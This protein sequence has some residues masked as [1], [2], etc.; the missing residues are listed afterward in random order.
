MFALQDALGELRPT[1]ELRWLDLPPAWVVGLV[2]L[3][4]L[5]ALAWFCYRSE[6]VRPG[7]RW[8][9]TGLRFA[10]LVA[11]AAILARPALVR[12]QEEV[13]SPEVMVLLDDSASMRRS[14]AYADDEAARRAIADLGLG[15]DA[16][17]LDVATRLLDRG[18]TGPLA[19]RGWV[20]NTLAFD[21][22]TRPVDGTEAL[23]ARG[24]ATHLGDA[25]TTAVS[26]YRGRHP[27][28]LLVLTDGRSNGGADVLEGA[29]VA[30]IAG[31]EVHSVVVGDTR[32]LKNA[33]LELVEAP[34]SALEGDELSFAVRVQGRGA[35]IGRRVEV[36]LEEVT[37]AGTRE[38]LDSREVELEAAGRRVVLVAPPGPGDAESGERR[39]ELTVPPLEDETLVDDNS[40]SVAVRV[41]PEKVRVLYVEGYPRWEYRRLALDFLKRAEKDIEFQAWLQ[42]SSPGFP[43]E[44]GP[45]SKP[46]ERLPTTREELLDA[47][48][49]VILGDVNPYRLFDDPA[50]GEAFAAALVSF[51][52]SGGGL[53]FQAGEQDNPRALL[54]TPLED[55]LPVIVD[56]S[57]DLFFELDTTK[58]FRPVLENASVPHE[59]VRLH[60]DPDTNRRLWEDEDGLQGVFW[61]SGVTRAKTSADV[62]LRH[63]NDEN[64][65]GR[66]PLLVAGYYPQGRTLFLALDSTWR[67]Q[68]QYG[69]RYFER[70]WK[71]AIRWLSLGRL[72][73][74]DRRVR[75]ETPRS[76]Y[77]LDE[78]VPLE[79]RLLGP[80]WRPSEQESVRVEIEDE[81]GEQRS[82][83]LEADPGR[84]GTFGGEIDLDQPGTYGAWVETEGRR[85]ASVA[86]EV[87]LPSKENADPTPD[88]ALLAAAAR[89]SGGTSAVVGSWRDVLAA[90]DEGRERREP[91]NSSLEDFWDR[92][93]VLLGILALLA[94]EW[95]VRKRAELL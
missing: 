13:L 19:D 54:G 90:F 68:W 34:A 75:L 27:V 86:F 95:L 49:V 16:S 59:I 52:E 80:D 65:F 78:A 85:A 89:L 44:H 70:F 38:L 67:W 14:D 56:T 1:A 31:L 10:A 66:R 47:Y 17:R 83:V 6:P 20:V 53:M 29:R 79:V 45:G 61:Y 40:A 26:R 43:Q 15:P 74:G 62:L 9:L 87:V 25:I 11:V 32:P 84:P 81:S 35:A 77:G 37:E 50:D 57:E 4:A 39:L 82:V 71:S 5:F 51:V 58:P 33:V 24:D 60:P 64:R 18:F 36:L 93:S 73:S 8:T 7:V 91:M 92:W 72:R 42:E 94:T 28:A 48:D 46:L 30:S 69:P 22:E 88:P 41:S 76:R 23:D 12:S 21:R 2:V 3:P 55:L 63:P